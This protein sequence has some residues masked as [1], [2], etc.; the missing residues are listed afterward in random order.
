[1]LYKC[2]YCNYETDASSNYCRHKKTKKHEQKVNQQQHE[3]LSKSNVNPNYPKDN[4][5][6][7]YQC[8][9]CK[10][11]FSHRQ[12]LTKHKKKCNNNE[13]NNNI[14][15]DNNKIDRLEKIIEILIEKNDKLMEK[16][17]DE[18]NCD[19]I[20]L[21]KL[22]LTTESLASN[23]LKFASKYLTDAPPLQRL[24]DY[25]NI[26]KP[27]SDNYTLIDIIFTYQT[28]PKI[29][30]YFGDILLEL[31]KKND[32]K[33]QS[34]WSSDT[35]RMS[36]IVKD[37]IIKNTNITGW[38][39]DNK[40]IRVK[41]IIINPLLEYVKNIINKYINEFNNDI[42]RFTQEKNKLDIL[43][44]ITIDINNENLSNEII[45]YMS[46]YLYLNTNLINIKLLT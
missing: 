3:A 4:L 41:H 29:A 30:K 25:S 9:N 34:L 1:M 45:K 14:N 36:Y 11:E 37:I 22:L 26:V 18:Q 15:N 5:K 31:Y 27:K 17:I 40:G 21:Q 35:S 16:I 39:K 20:Y 38:L 32:I 8:N 23:A 19:K 2:T 44:Q 33:E 13:N 28:T 7:K 10:I 24:S 6:K 42:I 43:F 12:S 46:P